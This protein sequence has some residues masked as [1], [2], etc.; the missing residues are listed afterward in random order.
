VVGWTGV[1]ALQEN[2]AFALAVGLTLAG[3]RMQPLEDG[4]ERDSIDG[5]A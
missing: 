1:V 4:Q 2:S 3:L 5:I